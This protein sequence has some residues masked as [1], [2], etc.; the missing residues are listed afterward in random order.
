MG[1]KITGLDKCIKMI[2]NYSKIINSKE[3]YEYIA[4]ESIKVI[5]KYAKSRLDNSSNYTSSNIYEI[6]DKKIKISNEVKNSQGKYYSL[7]IEYGSGMYAEKP[8]F[9]DTKTFVE[10]GY[11]YW[12][13][14]VEEGSN[15]ESYGFE[16]VDIDLGD[17]Q[18]N[19]FYK[20]F[21]QEPK[22]IY[23]DA[24]KEIEKNLVN[25]TM[26]FIKQKLK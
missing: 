24:A 22:H 3:L 10:S 26:Q 23:T 6:S 5:N 12:L 20:V 19:S 25:W 21:G 15:L 7:I 11:V 1:V 2:D 4:K 18:V 16:V 13:V 17:G 14:P 9:G 8:H